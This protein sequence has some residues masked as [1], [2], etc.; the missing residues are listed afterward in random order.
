MR[1]LC[2]YTYQSYSTLLTEDWKQQNSSL[3][4]NVDCLKGKTDIITLL[5]GKYTQV[6][7]KHF[8]SVRLVDEI[9]LDFAVS[10]S[11]SLTHFL[12]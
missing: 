3:L 11:P 8:C 6:S 10:V 9:R 7:L 12:P 1:T 5:A 4:P 2:T